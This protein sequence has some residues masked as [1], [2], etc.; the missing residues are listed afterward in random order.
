ME[1]E[2]TGGVQSANEALGSNQ[3]SVGKAL[4]L[5]FDVKQI[6][7]FNKTFGRQSSVEKLE[8]VPVMGNL[9]EDSMKS[10]WESKDP[11]Y[12]ESVDGVNIF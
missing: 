6:V 12:V 1:C 4:D 5:T 9:Q 3:A 11:G 7:V 10:S 8:I 2:D